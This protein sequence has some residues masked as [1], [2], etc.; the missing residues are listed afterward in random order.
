MQAGEDGTLAPEPAPPLPCHEGAEGVHAR[1][2]RCRSGT[3]QDECNRDLRRTRR[4][5]CPGGRRED[6]LRSQSR[7]DRADSH[8][9]EL[10]PV[11]ALLGEISTAGFKIE[12]GWK[13]M[14]AQPSMMAFV[15]CPASAA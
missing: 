1:A 9:A 7:F 10:A 6:R 15:M 2:R 12:A 11:E 3:Q 5:A 4:R 13:Q 14:S 8:L